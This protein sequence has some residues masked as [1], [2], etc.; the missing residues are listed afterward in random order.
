MALHA[1]ATTL[2]SI[3]YSSAFWFRTDLL[4]FCL[5][6][7]QAVILIWRWVQS[8]HSQQLCGCL[9]SAPLAGG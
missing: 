2:A 8:Q 1:R 6:G 9:F 3:L 7:E 4:F 5:R